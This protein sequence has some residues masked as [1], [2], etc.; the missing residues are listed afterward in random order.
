MTPSLWPRAV[1]ALG[2]GRRF[3]F[4]LRRALRRQA[5]QYLSNPT[6]LIEAVVRAAS[7]P[8]RDRLA[9]PSARQGLIEAGRETFRL[10]VEGPLLDLQLI[11]RPW[12]FQP[13]DVALVMILWFGEQDAEVP[14]AATRLLAGAFQ[15][16]E[17][18]AYPDGHWSLMT[19]RLEDILNGLI[20]TARRED[21]RQTG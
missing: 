3:P 9:E 8:D 10:G 19:T 13:A 17:A 7:A 16:S 4:L 18:R 11:S 6:P 15:R 1:R 12:G 21:G 2:G 20:T 5:G 14:P